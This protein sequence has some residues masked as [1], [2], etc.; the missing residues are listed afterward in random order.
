MSVSIIIPTLNEESCLAATLAHLRAQRPR[1]IIVVDGGSD[2]ATCRLATAADR[3][4]TGPRGRAS[5]MNLGAAHATGDNLLF[6]HADCM[7]APGALDEMEHWLRRPHVAAGCFTMRT[8]ADGWPYRCIDA[9]ATAR[10]RLT[11]LIY[12]DQGLFLRR[13]LF[14]RLGGFPPV[15]FM[16]DVVFSRTLR[17]CGRIVVARALIHVSARRWQRIG[18]V[19][20]TLRNWTL[21]ALAAAGIPP[22]RLA[23]YY[24][25]VR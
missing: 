1:E 24:P 19:R 22:D 18:L 12:G 20:Q 4:L 6:L 9:C 14:E 7:L 5:Q 23:A 10:V 17:R 3:L 2:D 13:L 8:Q 15:K 16:E 25:V 21:T 11:G